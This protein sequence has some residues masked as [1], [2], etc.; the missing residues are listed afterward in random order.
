MKK[1]SVNI[2]E[3]AIES[4]KI[5]YLIL[6]ALIV[7]GCFGL[8]KMNKAE[9]P[10]MKIKVALVAAVAPGYTADEVEEKVA[11]PL[12]ETLNNMQFVERKSL[13]TVSRDGLCYF[14]VTLTCPNKQFDDCLTAMRFKLQTRKL[15]LPPNVLAVLVID[16]FTEV[17]SLM[18]AMTSKDK[19]W[20]E[21]SDLAEDLKD[22]LKAIPE[23]AK[24]NIMGEQ[25]EEIAVIA[26][27]DR[28]S[29]YGVNPALLKLTYSTQG[30]VIPSGSFRV[31]G[32]GS[33]IYVEDSMKSVE[34]VKKQ[35]VFNDPTGGFVRLEDVAEVERR[36]STR[37]SA[38]KFNGD[39][40]ILLGVSIADNYDIVASGNKVEKV[41][42]QFEKESPDGVTITRITDQPKI[43]FKSV[44]NFLRDL[45]LS[46]LVVILVMLM[47]FPFKS[48]V[49]ASSGVPACT[50]VAL[51]IFYIVGLPINTVTLAGLIV[52]L[53]MIV[54]DSIVTMDGYMDNVGRGM[55]RTDAAVA[56]SKELF[57]PMLMATLSISLM[58]FPL[59]FIIKGSMSGIFNQFPIVICIAL[60]TSL[61]YALF[62]VPSLE[63]KHISGKSEKGE[64]KGF[65]RLQEKFF[66]GLQ[67]LYDK[68]EK[69]V[70]RLPK[71]TILIAI[72]LVALGGYLFTNLNVE[73]LPKASRDVFLA[74]VYMDAGS[75]FKRTE[76]VTDSL[77]RMM[78]EDP[79]V[80]NVT[81]FEGTAAPRFHATMAPA[82][83]NPGFAQLIINTESESATKDLA[84]EFERKYEFMF[85]DALIRIKQ[86]DYNV[87]SAPIE[88]DFQGKDRT[89][90]YP[91]ADSLAAF[92]NSDP[93]TMWVHQSYGFVP[94]VNV[95]L[96]PDETARLG[97]NPAY[98]ALAL[99]QEYSNSS[100]ASLGIEGDSDEVPL[101]FHSA[102]DNADVTY[103]DLRNKMIMTYSA[104]VKVPL[105]QIAELEP[106]QKPDQLVRR[107]G[108]TPSV[109]VLSDIRTGYTLKDVNARIHEWIDEN[110]SDLPEGVTIEELGTVGT[111]KRLGPMLVG[112]VV[113]AVLVMF[114]FLLLTFRK[115]PISLLT[116][117]MSLLCLFGSLLGLVVFDLPFSMT[118][119]LGII[120]LI[121]IIVRNGIL[122]YEYAEELVHGQHMSY[123]DAAFQAGARRMRPI[124]LTSCTTALGVL[125][126]IISQDALW[127]PMGVTI[128]LGV[129][130]TLP[131][132]VLVMPVAYWQ[133]FAKKDKKA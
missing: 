69:L 109:S 99:H 7:L 43:V 35:I 41:L 12:E 50:L 123:R 94:S 20:S 48:A 129:I 18:V 65:A 77:V 104:G 26:D 97:V 60:L 110:L 56:A 11:K 95:V 27:V 83:G 9:F 96:D 126:M 124:F 84:A 40:C 131:L 59:I 16:D 13:K 4:H 116:M 6:F 19:G 29:T 71:L 92:L 66:N 105:R 24:V 112:S 10:V 58:F 103:D 130:F 73:L 78:R 31:G 132:T 127:M 89:Q 25:S 118:A 119:L 79:R 90:L 86:M 51:A 67:N 68:G 47:L 36:M 121:G 81:A 39:N 57:I 82:V 54:D 21:M 87:V 74:E 128:C 38:V 80:E 108:A 117:S 111:N 91:L 1:K 100:L 101:V 49:I 55:W 2:V 46:I 98:V 30:M 3:A 5:V 22:R 76:A 93:A 88:I 53:G 75:D 85:P 125:P 63:V 28:L 107:S 44:V 120:S 122:M 15:T 23:V 113:A 42:R 115:I 61:A 32:Y 8:Y 102:N 114:F 52:V 33:K 14:Y 62:V 37:N 45:L 106:V 70:F 17:T 72:A 133:L 64:V 34:E